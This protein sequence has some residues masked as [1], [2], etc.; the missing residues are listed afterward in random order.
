MPVSHFLDGLKR[1]RE[2]DK[3]TE[4]ESST[5][6]VAFDRDQ[7]RSGSDG[8]TYTRVRQFFSC[9]YSVIHFLSS[10]YLGLSLA[11]FIY[12]S[13]VHP[14]RAS[15]LHHLFPCLPACSTGSLAAQSL[16]NNLV[17]LYVSLSPFVWLTLYPPT[18]AVGDQPLSCQM[19]L[20]AALPYPLSP[21]CPPC[22]ALSL[23][24][25]S[26]HACQRFPV[27]FYSEASTNA[28]FS[29]FLTLPPR[30]VSPLFFRLPPT[31]SDDLWSR[32]GHPSFECYFAFSPL[33]FNNRFY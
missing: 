26:S 19:M 33:L 27:W 6:K 2:G 14:K 5:F 4:R 16:L 11:Q 7:C 9:F 20:R 29:L 22:F 32:R 21:S 23:A 25:H 8:N 3:E 24:S 28:L 12:L 15:A 1:K 13:A 10:V 30:K 31:F 18:P 17:F